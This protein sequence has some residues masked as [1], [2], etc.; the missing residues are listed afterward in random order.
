MNW[1]FIFVFWVVIVV[2][3]FLSEIYRCLFDSQLY[4][5]MKDQVQAK[6][7]ELKVKVPETNSERYDFRREFRGKLIAST[8]YYFSYH[9]SGSVSQLI[10]FI[11]VRKLG[12]RNFSLASLEIE[13]N[14]EEF[15]PVYY[16]VIPS[17]IFWVIFIVYLVSSLI[18]NRYV[19]NIFSENKI[20]FGTRKIFFLSQKLEEKEVKM[21]YLNIYR[22]YKSRRYYWDLVYIALRLGLI[23][24]N[25]VFD[26]DDVQK[27]S[28]SLIILFLF[29][30]FE[31]RMRPYSHSVTQRL[32][33][34]STGVQILT[35]LG[36]LFISSEKGRKNQMFDYLI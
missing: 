9:M 36:A 24:V 18:R 26:S 7:S 1:I 12:D 20:S 3:I 33:I 11:S 22:S 16:V 27:L 29:L 30:F 13:Y 10:R 17:L 31:I 5:K 25:L 21:R 34:T 23:V 28:L 6:L 32:S 19:N 4:A 8:L 14:S 15:F 2:V 35:L